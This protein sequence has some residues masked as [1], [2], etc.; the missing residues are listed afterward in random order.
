MTAARTKVPNSG[1]YEFAIVVY[2][3]VLPA[4]RSSSVLITR[5]RDDVVGILQGR[6]TCADA[7]IGSVPSGFSSERIDHADGQSQCSEDRLLEREHCRNV[8][9]SKDLWV[10]E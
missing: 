10:I 8:K 6:T 3:D 2:T 7:A 9:Y 5:E 4:V 1:V